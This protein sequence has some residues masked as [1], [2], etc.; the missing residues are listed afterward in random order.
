MSALTNGW[1]PS[2]TMVWARDEVGVALSNITWLQPTR[3]ILTP[4]ATSVS[5]ISME[6][7]VAKTTREDSNG[8][9]KQ[10]GTETPPRCMCWAIPTDTDW[11]CQIIQE[12]VLP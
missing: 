8:L 12:R 11:V 6:S 7:S 10:P 5:S 9:T 3:E 4:N 1:G 2:M